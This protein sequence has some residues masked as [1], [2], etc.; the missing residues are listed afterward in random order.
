M[1]NLQ[2]GYAGSGLPL[3]RTSAG[4]LKLSEVTKGPETGLWLEATLDPDDPDAQIL[5]RKLASG[6][7]DGQASFSFRIAEQ[8]WSEDYKRRTV[9]QANLQHGDVTAVIH[10]ANPTT[11]VEMGP[12]AS[13][14]RPK[15]RS[16][17]VP[18]MA[19]RNALLLMARTTPRVPI[20]DY[21]RRV[22]RLK[23]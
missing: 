18:D 20:S 19:T 3:A 5:Q 13:A 1:L 4:S 10:G 23:G 17:Y 7:L 6:A 15:A 9:I 11:H 21:R 14:S 2:H 12:R 22:G 16:A 8:K